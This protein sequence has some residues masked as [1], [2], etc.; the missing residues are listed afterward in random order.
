MK[1]PISQ[2]L[3]CCAALVPQGARVADIGCDHGYLA[4]HLLQTGRA[5]FVHA[6]DLREKPLEKAKENA[7]RFGVA[8]N[9]RFSCA[10][11][12]TAVAPG[13]VDTV[14]CAG[15]GGDLIAQILAAASWTRDAA[16]RLILQPQS[17]GQDLRRTLA[18]WGFSIKEE[19]LVEDGGFLYYVIVVRFGGAV[20]LTPGEQYCSPALLSSGDPLLPAYLD[21]VERAL[22][23]TVEGLRR[24]KG[25][26]GEDKRDYYETALRE[27]RAMK[28]EILCQP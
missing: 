3:L 20:A 23:L 19:R 16:C 27:I 6:C 7:R 5:S 18:L 12:L 14:V 21:R 22:D 9:I 2:R 25:P 13:E 1:L 4:I 10:D 17:S 11:G 15:M 28:E 24:A 8:E 26:E